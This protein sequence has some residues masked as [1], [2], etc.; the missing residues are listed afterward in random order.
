VAG[1]GRG[2]DR[3]PVR[4]RAVVS[5][6]V[7]VLVLGGAAFVVLRSV[8]SAEAAPPV[9]SVTDQG[10]RWE[11]DGSTVV[12]TVTDAASSATRRSLRGR[13]ALGCERYEV[14]GGRLGRAQGVGAVRFPRIPG[15]VRVRPKPRVRPIHSCVL[16]TPVRHE[17]I[18]GVRFPPDMYDPITGGD[19]ASDDDRDAIAGTLERYFEA[20]VSSDRRAECASY[21]RN[22]ADSKA[23]WTK[24]SLLRPTRA[25][26][27]VGVFA[28]LDRQAPEDSVPVIP[29]GAVEARDAAKD[30]SRLTVRIVDGRARV[31]GTG[32]ALDGGF[33]LV[34][35]RGRWLIDRLP[36]GTDTL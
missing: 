13:V 32:T 23:R 21:T 24:R 12:I 27:C 8:G 3:V 11:L 16:E 25:T 19:A 9:R 14:I 31:R 18:S 10:V 22:A 26:D 2:W 5:I 34:Q 28:A 1:P 15:T 7:L 30:P 4:V 29:E 6:A 36:P 17:D 20:K 33:E 35:V